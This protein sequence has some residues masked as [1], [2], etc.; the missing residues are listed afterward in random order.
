MRK[1]TSILK[2]IIKRK[3]GWNIMENTEKEKK[4]RKWFEWHLYPEEPINLKSVV[5]IV[6]FSIIVFTC[7][8]LYYRWNQVPVKEINILLENLS[9][10]QRKIYGNETA[11]E[12]ISSDIKIT[13]PM[14]SHREM[15][16]DS[17]SVEINFNSVSEYLDY[18]NC[19]D[20]IKLSFYY[21]S[22]RNGRCIRDYDREYQILHARGVYNERRQIDGES[23]APYKSEAIK[24][25]IDS[26]RK[27]VKIN[28][29]SSYHYYINWSVSLPYCNRK[30]EQHDFYSDS[31]CNSR[32]IVTNKE[33]CVEGHVFP[34]KKGTYNVS[35]QSK[36]IGA[37]R[38]QWYDIFNIYRPF[39]DDNVMDTPRWGRLE[40]ISQ[41]YINLVLNSNTIDSIK[42]TIDFVGV[43]EFSKMEP[44]PDS[45]NMSRIVFTDPV[46]LY[47]IRVNGLKFHAKFVELENFQQI[48][49][50]SV[51]AIM[52]AFVL[53]FVIFLINSYFK[54][55]RRYFNS[56]VTNNSIIRKLVKTIIVVFP[57]YILIYWT[58]VY[59]VNMRY[60]RNYY[61][62]D[63]LYNVITFLIILITLAVTDR[64]LRMRIVNYYHVIKQKIIRKK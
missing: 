34:P 58:L 28:P 32:F 8:F 16:K 5:E 54:L 15:I 39:K 38:H 7:G 56:K 9:N 53:V 1:H 13:F 33:M 35:L 2:C 61:L 37:V 43:T 62:K 40:D 31:I 29:D 18:K 51:T 19:S 25:K 26:L 6:I 63:I 46:K 3:E 17:S 24:A 55:R 50:F 49:V 4:S 44:E 22:L 64:K 41:S 36:L 42:L 27:C 14:T 48:R 23:C 21:D 11:S 45:I 10:G 57:M 59:F 60:I 52:S 30:S 20:L 12:I 47:K